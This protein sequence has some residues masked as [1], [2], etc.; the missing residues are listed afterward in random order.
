MNTTPYA[1]ARAFPT[2]FYP[3]YT[4]YRGKLQWII[5]G[6][7]TAHVEN[8]DK[9]VNRNHWYEYLMWRSDGQPAAHPTFSLVLFNHKTRDALQKQGRFVLKSS[10]IGLNITLNEIRNSTDNDGIRNV[11]KNLKNN[12]ICLVVTYHVPLPIGKVQDLSSK[13][14]HSLIH[15]LIRVKLGCFILVV[16][17]NFM[18]TI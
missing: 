12:Y 16:L 4:V 3:V 8:R 18:N 11:V 2:L 14:L 13:Q 10:D 7:I 6:D 17:L 15:M 1:W 5:N 9:Y